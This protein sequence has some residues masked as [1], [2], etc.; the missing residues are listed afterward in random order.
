ML[1]EDA[2]L[3]AV[4]EALIARGWAILAYCSPGG[5]GG[6][7]VEASDVTDYPGARVVL[8]LVAYRHPWVIC[9]EAKA[10]FSQRDRA[11]LDRV[12][13]HPELRERVLAKIARS[14]PR[15][16]AEALKLV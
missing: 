11:K 15:V 12:L 6:F 1:S 7:T 5:H 9:L 13:G 14:L 3:F 4:K 8:D 10:K 2:I 16:A